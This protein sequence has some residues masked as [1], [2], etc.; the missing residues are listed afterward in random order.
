MYYNDIKCLQ[1]SIESMASL[2]SNIHIIV[3]AIYHEPINNQINKILDA[4]ERGSCHTI[5]AY[6]KLK[7]KLYFKSNV[8]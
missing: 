4:S 1:F 5:F 2:Q 7:K 8:K 3:Y 6:V